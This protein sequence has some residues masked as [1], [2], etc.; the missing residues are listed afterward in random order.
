MGADF[1]FQK[2]PRFD[3]TPERENEFEDLLQEILS[4]PNEEVE[5]MDNLIYDTEEGSAFQEIMG[6]LHLITD[7]ADNDRGVS[8]DLQLTEGGYVY[9]YITGGMSW[10]DPPTEFCTHFESAGFFPEVYELALTFAQEDYMMS[11]YGTQLSGENND[12]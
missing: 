2:F 1:I 3:M 4:D 7:T 6:A 9:M 11:V 10:G 5:F 12:Q 8:T